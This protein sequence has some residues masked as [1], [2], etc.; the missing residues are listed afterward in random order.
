MREQIGVV[1]D[2]LDGGRANVGTSRLNACD[3]CG[4]TSGCHSC[5]TLS[6]TMI[7]TVQNPI[8]ALSGDIVKIR[9]TTGGM[10]TGAFLMY[11]MPILGLMAG[12]FAGYGLSRTGNINE[13]A[14]SIILGLSGLAL[15]IAGVYYYANSR[16]GS[17][18]LTPRIAEI[19][20]RN[21]KPEAGSPF[22]DPE[23]PKQTAGD[24]NEIPAGRKANNGE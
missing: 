5:L 10:W 24:G 2:T 13:T 12:A 11:I 17:A 6:R 3:G 8:G 21:P 7:S 1:V 23:I 19:V 20:Q 15:G 22:A 9:H 18:G 14:A 4:K 16:G